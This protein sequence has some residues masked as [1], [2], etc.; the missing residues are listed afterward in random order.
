MP[1]ANIIGID[2]GTHKTLV[3][4]WDS[5]LQAPVLVRLSPIHGDDMPSSV[6]VSADG[7]MSFG[8]EADELSVTDFDGYKQAF[9]HDIANSPVPYFLHSHEFT[10]RDLTREYLRWIKT[11]VETESL[12]SP[13]DHAVVTVPA[14]WLPSAREALLAALAQVPFPSVELLDQPVAAAVA[15]LRSRRDLWAA[16]PLLVFDWGASSLELAVLTLNGSQLQVSPNLVAHDASLGG[17]SIDLH[18]MQAVNRRLVQLGLTKLDDRTS[19]EKERTRRIVKNWKLRHSRRA[20]EVWKV[21]CLEGI[22]A[23]SDLTWTSEQ[24]QAL[25][26]VKITE[27]ADACSAL[28]EKAKSKGLT[29]AGILLIGASSQFPSLPKILK[30]RLPDVP[31][32]LWD[33]RMAAAALGATWH[34]GGIALAIGSTLAGNRGWYDHQKSIL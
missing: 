16:G 3:A 4:R 22:G 7:R 20:N 32:L 17:E 1:A 29:P 10:A 13:V 11:Q 23:D 19:T 26:E 6:H 8:H 18:L 5:G 34:A 28:L 9:K 25:V 30:S 21:D 27:A 33:Q 12:H 14:S 2:F 31:V 15:L 24:I